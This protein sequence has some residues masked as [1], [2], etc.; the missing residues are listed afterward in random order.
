MKENIER[1]IRAILGLDENVT[2]DRSFVDLGGQSILAA[3][4]QMKIYKDTRI[5]VK[6]SDFYKYDKM[7][8]FI[9]SIDA[10]AASKPARKNKKQVEMDSFKLKDMQLAYLLGRKKDIGLGGEATHAYCEMEVKDYDHERFEKAVNKLIQTHEVLRY[11]FSEDGTQELVK[12]PV[13][14][15]VPYTDIQNMSKEQKEKYLSY[16]RTEVFN[17]TFKIDTPPLVYFEVTKVSE[18]N[19]IIHFC[20]D[21][22][23]VDGW[24]HENIV[25]DLD[26]Y[27]SN[28]HADIRNIDSSYRKYCEYLENMK[29]TD[30]YNS[31][32]EYWMDWADRMPDNPQLPFIKNPD[33]VLETH[34]RQVLRIFSKNEYQDLVKLAKEWDVSAFSILLTI[35]GKSIARCSQNQHFLLNVPIALRPPIFNDIWD[36]V[37]ECSNFMLFDFDNRKDE[38]IKDLIIRNNKLVLQLLD[39]SMYSGL[40]LLSQLQKKKGHKINAPV[41]FTSTLDVPYR[42]SQEIVKTYTKTHTSQVWID[43]VLMH[44]Q[45]DVIFTMD[46]VEE[47][48]PQEVAE[49]I[50]DI[51]ICG[52]RDI[53]RDSN[54]WAV[55]TELSLPDK[56][57]NT[58]ETCIGNDEINSK[59]T[60]GDLLRN[61]FHSNGGRIHI[62]TENGS[63]SYEDTFKLINHINA[64]A[65]A[66]GIQARDTIGIYTAKGIEGILAELACAL[67]NIVFLPFDTL[68]PKKQLIN[69]IKN[70]N[71][72]AIYT[73]QS[74]YD[75]IKEIYD[76][77]IVL[78]PS[79]LDNV[80]GTNGEIYNAADGKDIIYTINTSGTTGL[81]KSIRI[82]NDGF[83]ECLL[84]TNEKFNVTSED[85]AIAITSFCHDMSLYDVFGMTIA[86]GGIVVP[87]DSKAKD[88]KHWK[89]LM[90]K[91]SITIWNSVPAFMDMYVSYGLSDTCGLDSVRYIFLGG[92]WVKT[93]LVKEIKKY[94]DNAKVVSVGGPS[95]TT[96]WN[97]FHVVTEEDIRKDVIPYGIPFPTASYYILNENYEIC[98]VQVPG[99]MY[100]SG[101]CVAE[102]YAGNPEETEKKFL[103]LNG[104]RIYNT[105]DRG[106]YNADGEIIFL[107]R[108][109]SQVKINGKR[110]ELS[111]IENEIASIAGIQKC[112]VLYD[113]E[114]Q[115]LKSFYTTGDELE[116]QKV[117]K[118]I[119]NSLPAY[120]IPGVI[121][122]IDEMPLTN[123]G[124]IDKNAL[125]NMSIDV[126]DEG[127]DNKFQSDIEGFMQVCYKVFG[128]N[129]I[130]EKSNFYAI[131]GNSI[132]AIKLIAELRK[133]Y[134]VELSIYH[135]MNINNLEEIFSCIKEEKNKS[136]C[137]IS[138]IKEESTC[139]LTRLQEDI[140]VYDNINN[141]S[142]YVI[143]AYM[144]L[145]DKNNGKIDFEKLRTAVE[146][147]YLN[148][149]TLQNVFIQNEEGLPLRRKS[150]S[151]CCIQYVEIVNED[152]IRDFQ[153][154]ISEEKM[155]LSTGPLY[156][157]TIIKQSDTK[158]RLLLTI[159]HI[160]ADEQSFRLIFNQ[161]LREYYS[162]E[163][164]YETHS[165]DEYVSLKQ[166]EAETDK[167]LSID[168]LRAYNNSLCEYGNGK[169]NKDASVCCK[170][171]ANETISKAKKKAKQCNTSLFTTLLWSYMKVL[172]EKYKTK[173]YVSVPASDRAIGDFEKT[174]GLFLDKIFVTSANEI[175]LLKEKMLKAYEQM[176]GSYYKKVRDENLFENYK[177][178]HNGFIFNMIDN[179]IDNDFVEMHYVM[180]VQE[181]SN[182]DLQML[183]EKS[184]EGYYCRLSSGC[185]RYDNAEL[186]KILNEFVDVINREDEA[187]AEKNSSPNTLVDMFLASCANNPQAIAV[188]DSEGELSYAE[189]YYNIL[190]CAEILVK[191]GVRKGD[192]IAIRCNQ[193][194]ETIIW[195]YAILFA[196]GV[197][198]PIDCSLPYGKT[199]LI[200]TNCG[201]TYYITDESCE[202]ENVTIFPLHTYEKFIPSIS[203]LDNKCTE[204]TQLAYIMNTSG[205]T[206]NP[207]GVPIQQAGIVNLIKWYIKEMNITQ[208]S[209][210]I[211]LNN[212]GFDGSVK[213]LFAALSCGASLCLV[214]NELYDI[215]YILNV[216]SKEQITHAATVPSL[217]KEM[218]IEASKNNYSD[219]ES[220]TYMVCGGEKLSC[221]MFL[222]WFNSPNCNARFYNVYGPAECS[223]VSLYHEVT[224]KDID[225]GRI[226]IGKPIP[227][228]IV[229]L[230][231][232]EGRKCQR[233]EKGVLHIGGIGTFD[234]YVGKSEKES[235]II[236]TTDI[237]GEKL[238]RTGDV[239]ILNDNNEYEFLG[240]EDFQIKINGQ[241][242]EVEE[243]ES[244]FQKISKASQCA[245]NIEECDG[246]KKYIMY[247]V[248]QSDNPSDSSGFFRT[249]MR[250][251]LPES[252]LPHEFIALKDIPL[253]SNGKIDRSKLGQLK[254]K[255]T[256]SYGRRT[257][258]GITNDI[259]SNKT[260]YNQVESAW[261][262]ILEM[263]TVP[264]NK[265]FQ[266][267]GGTSLQYFR[268]QRDFEIFS[269]NMELL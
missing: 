12:E 220:I 51:F 186:E 65:L 129:D 194:N 116:E 62:I 92:D 190:R 130:D 187:V 23:V 167:D 104:K 90:E 11:R 205:T 127:E 69:S 66:N 170:A 235:N 19:T 110:I 63:Y 245:F 100:V 99:T 115:I 188:K 44:R 150:A 74:H 55:K 165:F 93:E 128:R 2:L 91:N 64:D 232:N 172:E 217:L 29:K 26:Y 30:V 224:K 78:I 111:A 184:E 157:V 218:V 73:D 151:A 203:L 229:Y 260:I 166:L 46:C 231:N 75:E 136:Q 268:L 208:E 209:K 113:R 5:R 202:Y 56:L 147:V 145:L 168:E 89:E 126:T 60:V 84:Y 257:K 85:R 158:A 237:F 1:I 6:V 234:G 159:H 191:S 163:V 38:S 155:N 21:G 31:S 97:I 146:K 96:L 240:R 196:G 72:K 195:I 49:E 95:E 255:R 242:V 149:P 36:M 171:L 8:E 212:F 118:E 87:T 263:D 182:S 210:L 39:H 193:N 236:D 79:S 112:V 137:V 176:H 192:N 83:A 15:T 169:Q 258:H 259:N 173:V 261:G 80:Q 52:I 18:D 108:T 68:L 54:N 98:P 252:Y 14:V 103:S 53:L 131:G 28:P 174:V 153:R 164:E 183:I 82:K 251:F 20:H 162:K 61:S 59:N 121:Q 77:V 70:N 25:K 227:N 101:I 143:T 13:E 141:N 189:L 114:K 76:G 199:K 262:K 135:I 16:K 138:E 4:I 40:E 154:I 34:T 216:I 107:G 241:R 253:N 221:E 102:C 88:P 226:P 122:K 211:L 206:G 32:Y 86:G 33:D 250:E 27:Y 10:K 219:F 197:Y 35:Y 201:V 230:L 24:S 22:L 133:V 238:Y 132:T 233:G 9:D 256:I 7:S 144:D 105:G 50:A 239:A 214:K 152:S 142:R 228:K 198:V 148:N 48:I 265:G 41:V 175:D 134:G 267:L 120:M 243:I 124:K 179:T 180:N 67:A 225:C 47:I 215:P 37:G 222:S 119:E 58:I 125:N 117:R 249:K 81:P 3:Q 177:A 246:K 264:G 223:C 139:D 94:F 160:L 181:N 244:V 140:W 17:H 43:A 45:D 185:G 71:V 269:V 123:N 213:H 204:S 247:Y 109:D 266:E 106:M 42:K 200:L 57:L 178:I 156:R 248:S 207:K 161:I 254:A